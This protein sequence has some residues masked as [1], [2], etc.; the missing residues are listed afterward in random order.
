MA[1]TG[2]RG[3]L[4]G[5]VLLAL[6]SPSISK[7]LNTT[8]RGKSILC[9]YKVQVILMFVSF[10]YI[11][12]FATTS[13]PVNSNFYVCDYE[14]FRV[15]GDSWLKGAV[16]FR[17]L[18][19]NKG[20]ALFFIQMI[21][22]LIWEGKI[23]V[24]ICESLFLFVSLSLLYKI[25]LEVSP[26]KPKRI[27][28][29]IGIVLIVM[30]ATIRAGGTCEEYSLPFVLYPMLIAIRY[31]LRNKQISLRNAFMMGLCFAFVSQIRLNN[32][33][34]IVGLCL[35]FLCEY[36]R[37]K[38]FGKLGRLM[39]MFVLGLL[40][41]YIPI[42]VYFEMHNALYDMIYAS[43]LF[44]FKYQVKK[45][46]FGMFFN[47]VRLLPC[48]ILP[49]I[50]YVNDRKELTSLFGYCLSISTVTFLTFFAG[51]GHWNYFTMQ[52]PILFLCLV[53]IRVPKKWHY[54]LLVILFCGPALKLIIS[55]IGFNLIIKT[56]LRNHFTPRLELYDF[57]M[58]DNINLRN[59][60]Y[61]IVPEI[62]RNSIYINGS[63]FIASFFIG[64]DFFPVGKYF[65]Q[66]DFFSMIDDV[67]GRDIY[68][69]FVKANPKWIVS[70]VPL[71]KDKYWAGRLSDYHEASHFTVEHWNGLIYIYHK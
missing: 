2:W 39:G 71:E 14:I 59:H 34:I 49:I 36:V 6:I 68:N 15:I 38:N 7:K 67:I 47:I 29:S 51:A 69:A 63:P 62:E 12:L 70:S 61:K 30:I 44:N 45:E 66:Q 37:K 21:G 25:G 17:D 55:K 20:P 5:I 60:I 57:Y 18:F 26:D 65:G 54:L 40:A 31:Y 64:T 42:I 53:M 28:L 50:A 9:D 24:Y 10:L 16:P 35:L 1:L 46:E 56:E 8:M 19:D 4:L 13:S 22:A 32:T 41:V 33:A 48:I 27:S 11:L 3:S 43:I 52:M 23:G 58:L